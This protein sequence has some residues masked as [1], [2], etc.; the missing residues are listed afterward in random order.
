VPG[1]KL[2]IPPKLNA[3]ICSTDPGPAKKTKK[4]VKF[5]SHINAKYIKKS[6]PYLWN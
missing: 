2:R 4:W 5:S 3:D 6:Q 1:R